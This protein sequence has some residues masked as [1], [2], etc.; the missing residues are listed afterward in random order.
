MAARVILH[1]EDDDD[2]ASLLRYYWNRSAIGDCT[3][4]RVASANEAIDYLERALAGEQ[5]IPALVLVDLEMHGINGLELLEWIHYNPKLSSVPAAVLSWWDEPRRI[6]RAVRLGVGKY[7]SKG[8]DFRG[9]V[10]R[11]EQLIPAP[12]SVKMPIVTGQGI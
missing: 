7:V 10:A 4:H 8:E 1:V 5:T 12:E 6:E 11:I 9:I 3:L 2:Y